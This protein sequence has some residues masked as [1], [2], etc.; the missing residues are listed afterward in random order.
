[1]SVNW[2]ISASGNSGL[3]IYIYQ[4]IFTLADFQNLTFFNT[5]YIWFKRKLCPST[6]PTG[7]YT[8][9]GPSGNG[10]NNKTVLLCDTFHQT[11]RRGLR[12]PG[13]RQVKNTKFNQYLPV[14]LT[15]PPGWPQVK[16]TKFNQYLPVLLTSLNMSGSRFRKLIMF[17]M[18]R[19]HDAWHNGLILMTA[20]NANSWPDVANHVTRLWQAGKYGK[21]LTADHG[22][23]TSSNGNIFRITGHLCGEFTGHR[24]ILTQRPVTRSFDVFFR[25]CLNKQLSKQSWGWWFEMLSRPLWCHCNGRAMGRITV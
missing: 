16:N 11:S 6:C 10:N 13:W 12:P 21:F 2:V 9:P 17:W 24:W 19:H 15:R 3:D 8:C 23:M 5:D 20:S 25:L 18:W 1:M 7:S 4:E 14:L 22:M